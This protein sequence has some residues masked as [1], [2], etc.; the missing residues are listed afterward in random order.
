M[1]PS[2]AMK[3]LQGFESVLRGLDVFIVCVLAG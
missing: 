3:A 1:A 2:I